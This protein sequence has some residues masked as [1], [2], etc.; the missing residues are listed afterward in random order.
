MNPLSIL[1]I[2]S[3][4]FAFVIYIYLSRRTIRI[5]SD[6]L[7]SFQEA[8]QKLSEEHRI[9]VDQY[10]QLHAIHI[11]FKGPTNKSKKK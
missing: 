7:I 5:L 10:R 4:S 3:I 2:S 8:G 11:A 6:T 9:L 1:L